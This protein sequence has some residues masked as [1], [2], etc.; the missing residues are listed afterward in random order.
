[1]DENLNKPQ[2]KFLQLIVKNKCTILS[3]FYF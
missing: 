2:S 3:A 1:M